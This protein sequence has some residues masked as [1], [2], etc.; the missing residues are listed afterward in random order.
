MPAWRTCG[1]WRCF[2]FVGWFVVHGSTLQACSHWS[3]DIPGLFGH[4]TRAMLPKRRGHP[5]RS[6][7]KPYVRVCPHTA[8][9]FV[10]ACHAYLGAVRFINGSVPLLQTMLM[11]QDEF[12]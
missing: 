1:P 11:E 7:S 5:R 2:V 4:A 6:A 8:P 9:Q 10:D 12:S 3:L